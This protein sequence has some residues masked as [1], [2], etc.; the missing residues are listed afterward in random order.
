MKSYYRHIL[1]TSA[2]ILAA[3][4]CTKTHTEELP[5][6]PMP[7][8]I[9]A[10][11]A[12]T[13][14][15]LLEKGTFNTDG[16]RIQVY[17]IHTAADNST[18]VYIDAYAGPDVASHSSQHVP[19][20]TWPFEDKTTGEGVSYN[21]TPDGVH[22]FFG[23]LAKDANFGTTPMTPEAY[24]G[25]GFSYEANTTTLTIP[26]T[27]MT[28]TS[29]QFDFLYSNIYTRDLN[30]A[31]PDFTS[32]VPLEFKHLF[33]AFSIGAWN[34]S[35]SQITITKFELRNL[36]NN[37]SATIN[38][39]GND[40][41]VTYGTSS[42]AATVYR[43]LE[44]E[45]YSIAANDKVANIFK[46]TGAAQEFTLMW[47]QAVE[48]VHSTGTITE[49][50]T[51]ET[52]YPEDYKMYIEYTVTAGEDVSNL[53]KSLN[54]PELAWEAG[55]KYH[56]DVTFADKMV[57]LIA[58][59]NEWDYESQVVDFKDAAVT[60]KDEKHLIWDETTGDLDV[61]TKQAFI[62]NGQPLKGH[63]TLDTPIGGTWLVSLSGDVD[64]FQITP[65]NGVIDGNQATISVKPLV[66]DPKRD[67]QVKLK[68]AVRRPDGRTIA[69][70]DA[71]QPNGTQ[72]TIVLPSN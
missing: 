57:E 61:S 33:T 58:S 6:T 45:T 59:V 9:S 28:P 18:S 34:T 72:Y 60:V 47:P 56:F 49:S 11:D 7:I 25:S 52:I 32:P 2:V 10:T 4:S 26:A 62:V 15:A 39:S 42:A 20:R 19:G 16:N 46:G 41:V 29:T 64:A 40:V 53:T 22:K 24:F 43:Q 8:S 66:G 38:Y 51:G 30:S 3:A 17:D 69:A 35:D 54:F 65:D 27:T 68:F 48:D 71:I 50:E 5:D 23:W 36:K 13:T 55:K 63:F 67:Y 12:T 14:K 44:N 31:T 70:D 1:L 21:W 37:K